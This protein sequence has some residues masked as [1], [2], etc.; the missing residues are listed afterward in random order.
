MCVRLILWLHRTAR[1]W[2]LGI[3]LL[4]LG[5]RLI[6]WWRD[7]LRE[8]DLGLHTRFV[9]KRFRDGVAIFILSEVMFFFSFFWS[10]FHSCLSPSIELGG[11]WP[12]PGIRTPNPVS[13]GLFNTTLLIRRGVFATYAHKSIIS[14]DYDKG[15]F[16]GL[17]LT[18]VCGVL[19]FRVQ[20]RE[21]YWNSFTIADSVYGR[22][23]YMLTGFHGIHVFVGTLWLI[24]RFGRLWFGHFRS[25][26]H[27]GLEACLWY[28]HFVDVVWVFVWLFVYLWFG[29]WIYKWWFEY[30][31]GNIYS[32]KHDGAGRSWFMYLEPKNKPDWYSPPGFK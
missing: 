27:F 4:R 28:W 13:T 10:F 14:R 15:S 32:F 19:F 23:F 31:G 8:G 29:G 26:R 25:R 6:S 22:T 2:L 11:R 30:W 3:R 24:V 7:L 16:Q 18:I 17:G 20:L 9:V 1:Y 5:L 21:Y 12:P